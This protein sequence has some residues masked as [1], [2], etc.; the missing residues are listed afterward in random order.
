MI[1]VLEQYYSINYPF[2]L[3]RKIKLT[4][5]WK[6]ITINGS[7]EMYIEVKGLLWNRWV[8]EYFI[9]VDDVTEFIGNCNNGY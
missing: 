5:R 6:L 4:G 3:H 2:P 7:S 8:S 1:R 9:S